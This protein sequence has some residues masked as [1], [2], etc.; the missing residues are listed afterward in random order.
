MS[1]NLDPRPDDN[2]VLLGLLQRLDEPPCLPSHLLEGYVADTLSTREAEHVHAHLR[3]CAVCTA[4]VARLQSMHADEPAF[5]VGAEAAPLAATLRSATREPALLVA[6]GLIGESAAFNAMRDQI[7]R[8]L[9]LS[10]RGRGLPPL[11]IEGETGTGKSV[12]AQALHHASIRRDGPFVT[13]SSAAIPE[14]LLESEMFGHERGAFAGPGGAK[15]GLF[16]LADH[17]T[18]F[19]DEIS[20]LGTALQAKL[21]KVLEEKTVWRVGS[22]R[23]ERV[24]FWIIAASATSVGAAVRAEQF[25]G[26][27]LHRLLVV[28][29]PALRERGN[30]VLLLAEHFLER[31]CREHR[32]PRRHLDPGAERALLAYSWPGNVRELERVIERAVLLTEGETITASDLA[33]AP[34]FETRSLDAVFGMARAA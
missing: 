21:L 26:D 18:V 2:H 23:G 29:I 15:P 8:L 28:R 14:P 25:R 3:Q 31:A 27:L 7:D 22:R 4:A 11:L 24:D 12:L 6:E 30:D 33:L 5:P 34:A 19:V 16:H 17:G 1:P 20:L 10:A 9:Q 32:L 13:V